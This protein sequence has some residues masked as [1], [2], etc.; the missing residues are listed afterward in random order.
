MEEIYP[1]FPE[2]G[3]Q[4]ELKEKWRGYQRATII[5]KTPRGFL[6]KVSSG[7]EIEVYEDEIEFD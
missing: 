1:D 5:D 2:Y 7:A 4:V 6:V 3:R